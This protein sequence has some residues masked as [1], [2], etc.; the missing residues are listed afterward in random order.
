[1]NNT[2]LAYAQKNAGANSQG[3]QYDLNKMEDKT[4]RTI[5]QLKSASKDGLECFILINGG[6]RSSKHIR[7]FDDE[8]RFEIIHLIDGKEEYL[9][10]EQVMDQ[11]ISNIGDAM[12]KGALIKDN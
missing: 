8:N 2:F 11:N 4:I 9:T 7:Y 1:M 5:E 12:K 3:Y 10:P 6:L